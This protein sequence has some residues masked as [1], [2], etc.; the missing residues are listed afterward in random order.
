MADETEEHDTGVGPSATGVDPA[1]IALS[2]SGDRVSALWRRLKEHRIAQWS[3]GYIAVAYGIQHAVVLTTESLD[4]PHAVTRVSMLLLA[5]GLPF[6]I[7]FAWYHGARANHRISGPEL[8]IISILL[9]GISLLFYVFIRPSEQIAARPVAVAHAM[10][11]IAPNVKQAGISVAVLP[12]LNL[13]GDPKEEYFSD[14]MTEEITTALAKIPKLP[15][16]GR[17]SAFA[18]KGK[19]E[20]MSVIGQALHATYLLEGSV[21]KDGNKVRITAQL[22]KAETGDHLWT[23]SY[24]RQLSGIFA[25]QEDVAKAIAA[26]LQVPLGLKEGETLVS[27]RTSD[28]QS[29]EDYLRALALYRARNI[30]EVIALLEPMVKRD[31]TYAPAWALLAQA[32]NFEP[33]YILDMTRPVGELRR[34]RD[35]AY[36]LAENAARKAIQLDSN[37]APGYTALGYAM[38]GDDHWAEADSAFQK[39]LALD[40]DDPDTLHLYSISLVEEGRLKQALQMR[41]TLHKLEPFVPIYNV[42]TAVVMLLNGDNE[43]AVTLL[44][45]LPSDGAVGAQR[46]EYLAF[47]YATQGRYALAAD[48]IL[49]TAPNLTY[50]S[51]VDARQAADIIRKAPARIEAAVPSLVSES[52]LGWVY[53]FVGAPERFLDM[54]ERLLEAHLT[55]ARVSW[56]IFDPSLSVV[57]KSERFKVLMRNEG[58]IDYWRAHGWSDFCRPTTGDDFE[59]H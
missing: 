56:L 22:I 18:F 44:E 10:T 54:P 58:L 5:L 40:P 19:S 23:D 49:K 33:V 15:V 11:A 38:V 16:V 45:P 42:Y 13:S 31:P 35:S 9:V 46:N 36:G 8:T 52:E 2:T 30:K 14:G 7:T 6:A 29:Y 50:I 59:C 21:R 53:V 27:N 37:Y 39:A 47:A 48:T 25:V 32:Y 3:L 12:F 1:A 17:T 41:M 20:D 4:W 55:G 24:D 57:H 34:E 28:T 51:M 43:G 26:A